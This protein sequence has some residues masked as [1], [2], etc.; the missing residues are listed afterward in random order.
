MAA[1]PGCGGG[2]A[3]AFQ[4]SPTP[5]GSASTVRF[6]CPRSPVHQDGGAENE[7]GAGRHQKRD[8]VGGVAGPAE[9]AARRDGPRLDVVG[10]SLRGSRWKEVAHA[11]HG[12]PRA[13]DV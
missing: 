8:K 9:T 3:Q 10:A 13:D 6:S 4:G 5:F 11:G 12:I 7:V 1:T 2:E